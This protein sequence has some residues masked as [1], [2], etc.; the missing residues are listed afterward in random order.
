L[1]VKTTIAQRQTPPPG[2][3]PAKPTVPAQRI[4]V[5]G[6]TMREEQVAI[7]FGSTVASSGEGAGQRIVRKIKATASSPLSPGGEGV[8]QTPI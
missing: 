3:W 5:T 8:A 4:P 1:N 6:K 7:T 2:I